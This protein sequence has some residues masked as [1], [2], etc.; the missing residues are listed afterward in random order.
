MKKQF[1][2]LTVLASAMLLA[3]CG[4]NNNPAVSSSEK[5]ADT[6]SAVSSKDEGSS[7]AKTSA[8][9]SQPVEEKYNVA[10][11]TGALFAEKEG[12]YA[13]EASVFEEGGKR[14]VIY[15]TNETKGVDKV[16]FALREGNKGA[17]GKWTY[18]EKKTILSASDTGWDKTIAAPSVV[19][20][21]FVK[22]EDTY[23]YL[24]AYQGNGSNGNVANSIGFAVAKTLDGDWVKLEESC[25]FTY[26]ADT[27][28][29]QNYGYGSPELLNLGSDGKLVMFYSWGETNL[30][31]TRAVTLNFADLN[32]PVKEKGFRDVTV[33]GLVD[34][35]EF[36]IFANAGF[37]LDTTDP[38]DSHILVTRDVFPL[39]SIAPGHSSSVEIAVADIS[40]VDDITESWSH[41]GEITGFD[42]VGE[43]DET[44]LG[45]D[46]IF[47]STF[48]TDEYGHVS[49][50]EHP[51]VIY[52]ACD[53]QGS[54]ES[55][56]RFSGFLCSKTM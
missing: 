16:S 6:S 28:G 42:T 48:V 2:F 36:T 20:G 15:S 21:N 41:M 10:H 7:E 19:K 24:M 12:F 44:S 3:S 49:N 53:G 47:A 25:N 11:G 55:D 17:D 50:S 8:D 54:Y 22:G 26:D 45:W 27:Y 39:S 52:S 29:E 14:Y 34:K 9:D 13:R 18:G 56:Y 51:E 46:Q 37:A 5:P 32:N 35:G 31:S 4:G 1:R 40:I 30:S 23:H 43:T 33:K 38:N